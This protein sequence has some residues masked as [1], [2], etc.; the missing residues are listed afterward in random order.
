[1]A[2]SSSSSST[3]SSTGGSEAY[4]DGASGI[5]VETI[6]GDLVQLLRQR[7]AGH[8]VVHQANCVSKGARGLAKALFDAV[9]EVRACVHASVRVPFACGDTFPPLHNRTQ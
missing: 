6:E 1:M 4:G 7:N 2:A 9:P 3:Q 8:F 5:E